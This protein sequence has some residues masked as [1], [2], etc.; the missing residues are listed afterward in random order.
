MTE[1]KKIFSK[2]NILEKQKQ[3]TEAYETQLDE[4][5]KT[6]E[7]VA[8]TPSGEK[9]FKYLFLLGGGDAPSARRNKE[10]VIDVNETLFTLGVKTVYETIKCNLT[11]ETRIKIEKTWDQ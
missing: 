11:T 8:K 9:L 4:V 5:R 3:A 7:E 1:A 2:R 10:G 6:F